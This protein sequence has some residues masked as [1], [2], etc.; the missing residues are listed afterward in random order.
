MPALR[1]APAPRPRPGVARR[2]DAARGD[3]RPRGRHRRR[4]GRRLAPAP[5]T[6]VVPPHVPAAIVA[7]DFVVVCSYTADVFDVNWRHPT[8]TW[9]Q[10]PVA[11]VF[12]VIATGTA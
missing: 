2:R 11:V 5:P 6:A 4:V 9:E 12:A 7:A 8:S 1:G 3:R 10:L